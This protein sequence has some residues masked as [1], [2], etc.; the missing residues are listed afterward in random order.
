MDVMKEI[1]EEPGVA[2]TEPPS[3]SSEPLPPTRVRIPETD[4]K[5]SH[6]MMMDLW[7]SRWGKTARDAQ[8]GTT[9]GCSAALLPWQEDKGFFCLKIPCFFKKWFGLK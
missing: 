7:Q 4:E 9:P 5:P 2:A 8:A 3:V 1:K 6:E